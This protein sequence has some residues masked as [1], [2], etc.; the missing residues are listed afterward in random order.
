MLKYFFL[1]FILIFPSFSFA[2]IQLGD[3]KVES[4]SE[5]FN[6]ENNALWN[7]YGAFSKTD[8]EVWI[9]SLPS[10]I[11]DGEDQK[12]IILAFKKDL[13]QD[14]IKTVIIHQLNEQFGVYNE[15][16]IL[17]M[18]EYLS[19]EW[20]KKENGVDYLFSMSTKKSVGSLN[21]IKN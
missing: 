6:K 20:R 4:M 14:S 10:M 19:L 18:D 5:L 13:D 1:F 11:I 16:K 8:S 2:Q 15:S 7:A 12:L 9:P 3:I 21:I 17:G